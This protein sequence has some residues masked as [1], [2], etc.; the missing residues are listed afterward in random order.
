ML[1]AGLFKLFGYLDPNVLIIN[2]FLLLLLVFGP[3]LLVT[4][5][6]VFNKLSNS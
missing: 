6:L 4:I 1:L 3:A 2:N 5:I